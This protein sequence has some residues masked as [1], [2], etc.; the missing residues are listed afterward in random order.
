MMA[1]GRVRVVVSSSRPISVHERPMTVPSLTRPSFALFCLLLL[2]GCASAPAPSGEENHVLTQ[3]PEGDPQPEAEPIPIAQPAP[4]SS[5][6]HGS[7]I[8][9]VQE[10]EAYV[11]G[12]TSDAECVKIAI[13]GCCSMSYAALREHRA[14][15]VSSLG[16]ECDR[17]C[18]TIA[19]FPPDGEGLAPVCEE[20]RCALR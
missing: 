20:G 17:V 4:A 9:G 1:D 5:C 3:D 7:W 2:A 6:A 15:Y 11:A 14:C 19:Q 12:C 10:P 18:E 13:A 8:P 16:S